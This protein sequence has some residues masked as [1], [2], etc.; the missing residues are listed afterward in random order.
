MR[1]SSKMGQITMSKTAEI[2]DLALSL[3]EKG[4]NVINMASGELSFKP[5]PSIR[6]EACRVINNGETLYTQVAGLTELRELISKK[7]KTD[8]NVEYKSDEIIVSNGGKQVIFNALQSTINKGDEVII[9]S[10]Y[11]VSYPEIVKLCGGKPK[12]L[13]SKRTEDFSINTEELEKLITSKTKWLILNSP[14][15]P[16]GVVY[17]MKNLKKIIQVLNKHPNV[18]ILLDDIYEKLNFFSDKNINLINVDAKLKRR[19]LIVNGFSKG[20]CMTGWRLGYGAGPKKLIEA[21]KKIQSQST[22]AANTIAQNAAIKALKLDEGYFEDIKTSL[23][24]RREIVTSALSD[25]DGFSFN[26]SQGAFYTFPSIKNFLGKRLKGRDLIL[27]DASFCLQ[28]LSSEYVATVPGS[29]FGSKDS[30]R[31]SYALS[32]KDL[33]IGCKRIKDFCERLV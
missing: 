23:L 29:S 25:L 3:R 8:L 33:R 27:N 7:L 9:V 24:K 32:E 22:S 30:I 15:N 10:P 28:L 12:V 20:Y 16:T 11:W 6:K 14:N 17:S 18:W 2:A 4:H 21:M 19:S 26:F 1:F 5:D 31:L 13:H